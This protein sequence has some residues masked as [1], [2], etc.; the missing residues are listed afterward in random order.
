VSLRVLR[1]LLDPLEL[2][3]LPQDL[4]EQLVQ[5]LS[6]VLVWRPLAQLPQQVLELQL[7]V[8]AWQL[9]V[10]AWQLA[11]PQLVRQLPVL[12]LRPVLLRLRLVRLV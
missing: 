12:E 1:Q 3:W 8:L 5:L 10:L 4:L 9:R 6:R 7:R 11:R 2:V